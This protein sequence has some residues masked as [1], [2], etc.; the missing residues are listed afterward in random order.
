M[1]DQPPRSGRFL[2]SRSQ[3]ALGILFAV[4]GLAAW[5]QLRTPPADLVEAARP[6]R[7]DYIVKQFSAT[8]TDQTG[9]PSRRLIADELRH[10]TDENLSELDQPRMDLFEA[11][12]PPW[13]ARSKRGIVFAGGDRIRLLDDVQLDRKGDERT[14]P[15]HLETEQIDIWR[16]QGLAETDRPVRIR[17]DGDTL[18][19]NGMRLWYNEPTR[20]T[21]HG[22]ARIQFAPEQDT[23]P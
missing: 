8:E 19:A 6:R 2:W 1:R 10:Y 5:W 3:W 18:T 14:R 11:E 23:P 15:T 12:G 20:T 16:A 22:R 7:P 17:S 9:T 21:F 4:S 13:A